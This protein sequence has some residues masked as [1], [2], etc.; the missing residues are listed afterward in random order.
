MP[1]Y[2]ERAGRPSAYMLIG[3]RERSSGMVALR[4]S[5]AGRAR[6]R[7]PTCGRQAP[8]SATCMPKRDALHAACLTTGLMRQMTYACLSLSQG[9]PFEKPCHL[10][11]RALA[12]RAS[13]PIA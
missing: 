1:Y 3:T 2:L 11:S 10:L 9:N 6:F 4:A 5:G 12:A 13:A 7:R 8:A